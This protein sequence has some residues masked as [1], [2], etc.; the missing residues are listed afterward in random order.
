[1]SAKAAA[2]VLSTATLAPAVVGHRLE[3]LVVC[4]TF[5]W[6]A[7]TALDY[8]TGHLFGLDSSTLMRASFAADA[9]LWCAALWFA[10]LLCSVLLP[11]DLDNGTFT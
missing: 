10:T 4:A 9:D 3:L 2:I 5:S 1:M 11:P 6:C 8:A 7:R